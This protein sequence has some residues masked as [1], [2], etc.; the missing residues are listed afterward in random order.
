MSGSLSFDRAAG[1][2]DATRQTDDDTLRAIIEL[3][4]DELRPPVL[5]IGV[6][7]GQLALPLAASGVRLTGL[8]LS[9]E[10]LQ[11]LRAKPHGGDLPIIRGDATVL[12]FRDDAFGGAYARWVL[13]LV[14]A[15]EA[16]LDELIRVAAPGAAIAIEPGGV[17]G[18][19][20]ELV[21][22]YVALLGDV[23]LSPGLPPVERGERLDAA[24]ARRG[25]VCVRT[26]PVTYAD[27]RSLRDYFDDVPRR[28][29]SWTW[30]VPDPDLAEATAEVRAWAA[31]R[32]DLDEPQEPVPTA[33]HVYRA[34]GAR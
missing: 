17:S 27:G 10:M 2:Y 3:L 6:G 4:T 19:H 30:R 18:V 13:H 25:W 32:F 26:A 21:R 9:A 23:A 5:E 15:W 31:E 20:A 29:A 14:P 7:T 34:A 24:M 28:I 33:W 8:D 1:Y 11:T 22:R 12:P 16:V